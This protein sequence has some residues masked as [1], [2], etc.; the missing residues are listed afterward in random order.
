M[1]NLTMWEILVPSASNA[2]EEYSVEY[3]QEWDHR[4]IKIAG[5][6]TILK[7]QKGAWM[8]NNTED[9]VR[10]KMIAVRIA[11]TKVQ[12][13]GIMDMTADYYDQEAVM[14]YKISNC[15]LVEDYT[16]FEEDEDD[17]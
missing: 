5:G 17:D 7:S 13:E 9:V 3:H 11:C 16:E 2:G 8:S 6:L 14:A 1:N 4:V 15:V 12:I 10:D